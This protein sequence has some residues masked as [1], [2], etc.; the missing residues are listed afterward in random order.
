M[1]PGFGNLPENVSELER[2][3][4]RFPEAA[5]RAGEEYAPHYIANF[6]IE[7]SRSF[8]TYYGNTKI[9]DKNDPL[10]AYRVALTEA[11]SIVLRNGLHLLG[12]AAPERM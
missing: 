12:I 5:H 3:L 11:F 2:L 10:S 8:N 4:C 6:L 7:L 1:A 9:I